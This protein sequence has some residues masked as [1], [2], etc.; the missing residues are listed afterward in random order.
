VETA[1]YRY[2][3]RTI[4]SVFQE[5]PYQIVAKSYPKPVDLVQGLQSTAGPSPEMEELLFRCK[6]STLAAVCRT[7]DVGGKLLQHHPIGLHDSRDEFS[8][9]SPRYV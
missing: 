2:S 7:T 1:G 4:R 8:D 5:H 9:I 3:K 6:R